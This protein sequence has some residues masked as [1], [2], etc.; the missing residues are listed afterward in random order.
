MVIP[1]FI[2]MEYRICSILEIGDILYFINFVRG[3]KS[4]F[5]LGV[6]FIL[7]GVFSSFVALLG[8][9]SVFLLI[10][11]ILF[12]FIGILI[13]KFTKNGFK[14]SIET[15]NPDRVEDEFQQWLSRSTLKEFDIKTKNDLQFLHTANKYY[16]VIPELMKFVYLDF[17]VKYKAPNT[18]KIIDLNNINKITLKTNNNIV[19]EIIKQN[20][21]GRA[22]VGGILFGGVGAIV[23]GISAK[24]KQ[25]QTNKISSIVLEIITNEVNNPYTSIT[26]YDENDEMKTNFFNMEKKINNMYWSLQNLLQQNKEKVN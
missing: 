18:I 5:F 14:R 11:G 3:G 24:E 4:M 13:V 16:V 9:I 12:I 26:L 2:F 19:G 7:I 17:S 23:G 6:M 8:E 22:V 20:A 21:I 15:I 1:K 10:M 25:T